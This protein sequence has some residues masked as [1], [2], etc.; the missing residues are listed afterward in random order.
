M[1]EK[2]N[3]IFRRKN[4]I[5][6]MNHFT[7]II[8]SYNNI[9]WIEKCIDSVICQ[10]YK[11]FDIIYIDDVSN[12][13]SYELVINKYSNK[14]KIIR[15]EVKKY[16]VGNYLT[17]SK[18]SKDNTIFVLL[19]GDDRLKND[20]VLDILNNVYTDDVWMTYGSYEN[21]EGTPG[22]VGCYSE[23]TINNNSF[24][25][26]QWY[27]SHLRTCRKELFSLI[28]D[29]DLRDN[30]G[31][32]YKITGDLAIQFPMLEMAGHRI[33]HIDDVL[34][35]YNRQNILSEDKINRDMQLNTE[36]ILR[37]KSPYI[38][39]ERLKLVNI[40]DFVDEVYFINL[41]RRKDRLKHIISE[42]K[43]HDIK[44]RRFDAIDASKLQISNDRT[45]NG[46]IGALRSHR[47]VIQDAISKKQNVICVFEDDISFCDDFKVRFD[48]YVKYVP[49]DWD[50][51]YLGCHF[52]GC[53]DPIYINKSIYRIVGCFGCFAMILNN[54][55]GLFQKILDSSIGESQPIDDCIN[56]NIISDKNIKAYVL[57]P[58]FV[59]TIDTISDISEKTESYSY[60]VVNKHFKN[61][62]EEDAPP[63][64]IIP[65]PIIP[66]V[67]Q[68]TYFKTQQNVC[69]DY[70]R[71]IYPFVIYYNG[72]LLFDSTSSD[73][74]N[75]YFAND[76]FTLYGKY[77]PYGGM[78][79][80]RK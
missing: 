67:V 27:A 44:A 17:A 4:N 64:P 77:F 68:Q 39:L 31:D 23:K 42:F 12:D 30:E 9:K 54:K 70:L 38:R 6:K 1:I 46:V 29:E 5:K 28:K 16:Q 73:K 76:H 55:N 47:G 78:L 57:K 69:D 51:M 71:S 60:D 48:Y 52:H 21:D 19:D 72:R 33:K 18:I 3:K 45:R 25:K 50:I 79:I 14:I 40:N 22:I 63:P 2:L 66:Q 41:K 10:K 36:K 61:I 20:G 37:D 13:G 11:N 74:N 34:Y 80:K 62:F 8:P 58:F 56:Y 15:N 75:L 53:E 35:V 32:Y 7:I 59:K 49:K 65:I 24:R 43:K 26:D